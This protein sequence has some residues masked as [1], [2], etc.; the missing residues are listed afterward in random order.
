MPGCPTLTDLETRETEKRHKKRG[1]KPENGE[2]RQILRE[3]ERTI[4]GDTESVTAGGSGGRRISNDS[5]VV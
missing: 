5:S 4:E 1:A 2:R 3:K